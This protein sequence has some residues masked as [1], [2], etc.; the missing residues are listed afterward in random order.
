M[1]YFEEKAREFLLREINN[2]PQAKDAELLHIINNITPFLEPN[3]PKVKY[4]AWL[5]AK[6]IIINELIAAGRIK[7]ELSPFYQKPQN[8][9]KLF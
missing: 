7:P 3:L 9:N 4:K 5:D 1:N 8:D 6:K 2:Y